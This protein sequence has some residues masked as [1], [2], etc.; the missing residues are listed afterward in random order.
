MS[1]NKIIR[2]GKATPEARRVAVTHPALQVGTR[3][4]T[5]YAGTLNVDIDTDEEKL[6]IL[7]VVDDPVSGTLSVVY[8]QEWGASDQTLGYPHRHFVRFFS[9]RSEINKIFDDSAR[10]QIVINGITLAKYSESSSQIVWRAQYG[11]Y[12]SDEFYVAVTMGPY[13]PT[14]FNVEI[15]SLGVAP[16]NR[17]SFTVID[18]KSNKK[19]LHSILTFIQGAFIGY[20]AQ[21][22]Y[23]W[24]AGGLNRDDLV[25]F[26]ISTNDRVMIESAYGFQA[27]TTWDMASY[28]GTPVKRY[29]GQSMLLAQVN[30]KFVNDVAALI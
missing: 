11:T 16:M 19:R 23:A 29:A 28:I 6:P 25:S 4:K 21:W 15:R 1:L 30:E 9:I 27:M 13:G 10:Y 18:A 3:Y 24:L 5:R 20:E 7:N 22:L 14:S 2:L 8:D 17:I 26:F 12:E